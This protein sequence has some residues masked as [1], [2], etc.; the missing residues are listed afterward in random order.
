MSKLRQKDPMYKLIFAII[1]L[2]VGLWANSVVTSLLIIVIMSWY[3]VRKGGI[4]LIIFIRL[5]MLPMAFLVIGVL[6]IGINVSED[7]NIFLAYIPV[8]GT[9]IG[10]SLSG[11]QHGI[12]IFFKSLAAVSCLYF[13]ALNTPMVDILNTLARLKIPK[14]FIELM[15]LIYR[16]IFVLLETVDTMFTAQKSR[17]G[18]ASFSSG[19]P[20]LAATLFVRS[21]K[22]AGD[23]Y[24][25]LEARGYE[26]EINVLAE[27]FET[28]K[29]QYTG[30]IFINILLV[31]ITLLFK[32]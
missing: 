1:T 23:L 22:R 13:L 18:Y 29:T 30:P 32:T 21:Y 6:I 25:A 4:P 31:L 7:I 9:H 17:M 14:L 2:G 11:L 24:T 3:T 15:G 10:V 5:M 12:I 19:Y 27:P 8:F 28:G 20:A 26:E 16:F